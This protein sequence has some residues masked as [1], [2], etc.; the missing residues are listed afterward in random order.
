MKKDNVI[1]MNPGDPGTLLARALQQ[2]EPPRLE[3]YDTGREGAALDGSIEDLIA[4][5]KDD[6]AEI[7]RLREAMSALSNKM[8]L[9]AGA[10][11]LALAELTET[12]PRTALELADSKKRR[13]RHII[14]G[15]RVD[16]E[17]DLTF[18][19]S[20]LK[21]M[22]SDSRYKTLREKYL[23]LG[24]IGV[25][26]TKAKSLLE[27]TVDDGDTSLLACFTRDL[28]AAARSRGPSVKVK[29]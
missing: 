16:I 4:E 28:Q 1:D 13:D 26:L 3:V 7:V 18:D 12:R 6:K 10:L 19:G 5:L 15:R 27:A 22:W 25:N 17:F 20:A 11:D 2:P 14:A 29:P 23:R 24:S 8:K 21:R 9:W